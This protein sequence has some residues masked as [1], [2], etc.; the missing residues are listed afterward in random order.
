[1][2][3]VY[4]GDGYAGLQ[5]RVASGAAQPRRHARVASEVHADERPPFG[6]RR[7]AEAVGQRHV[8]DDAEKGLVE[9]AA[10]GPF[11]RAVVQQV[12]GDVCGAAQSLQRIH[13]FTQDIVA[14]QRSVDACRQLVDEAQ[15]FVAVE[16]GLARLG[17]LVFR[18]LARRDVAHGGQDVWF[19][20]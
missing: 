13:R 2:L 6:D 19:A 12:D 9:A 1:M 16:Q 5:A 11:Q 14:R 7:A 10:G 18:C 20:A 15:A 17:Q 4:H 3:V 8:L